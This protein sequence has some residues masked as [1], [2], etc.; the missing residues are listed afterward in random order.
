MA[1]E[2][3]ITVKHFVNK[4]LPSSNGEKR[5]IYLRMRYDNKP[6]E[7]ESF[8]APVIAIRK[9]FGTGYELDFFKRAYMTDTELNSLDDVDKIPLDQELNT[10]EEV[11]NYAKKNGVNILQE[12]NFRHILA[13]MLRPF[14]ISLDHYLAFQFLC[15]LP[16][17]EPISI[18]KN[19]FTS[20]HLFSYSF[21]ALRQASKSDGCQTDFYKNYIK[22]FEL[23]ALIL[24]EVIT[25]FFYGKNYLVSGSIWLNNDQVIFDYFEKKYDQ[26]ILEE[27]DKLL[28]DYKKY[29]NSFLP[30]ELQLI[31][32][33]K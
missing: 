16:K 10:V 15:T 8:S 4:K 32:T 20:D 14:S 18:F 11:F 24:D 21:S 1:K 23:K 33:E 7:I 28:Q 27:L 9:I 12:L 2:K 13:L 17:Y 22:P 31:Y 6:Y 26:E 3:K 30:S 25:E 5:P 29:I 19:I